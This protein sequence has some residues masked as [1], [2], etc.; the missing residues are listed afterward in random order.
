MPLD[1]PAGRSG[2]ASGPVEP[3][4]ERLLA[5]WDAFL[6]L[7][8]A[9]ARDPAALDR[10]SRLP[11][12]RAHD[13]LVHLGSWPDQQTLVGVLDS[14]RTGAD[15][16]SG[17]ADAHN[18]RVV[19]A[20]RAAPGPE[21]LAALVEARDTVE[22]FVTGPEA[23][24]LGR[25]L[26]ASAVGPMPVLA[27]AHAGAYELAVHAL[28]LAPAGAPAPAP[29]LLD[30][31]LGALI[32]VTGGLAARHGVE[33]DVAAQTPYGG[34]R[35]ASYADGGWDTSPVPA[36]PVQGTAVLGEAALLLDVSGGRVSVPPQLVSGRLRVQEMRSF[37]RL[38][39]LV[40]EVPGLPGGAAL[41]RAVTGV[42][43]LTAVTARLSRRP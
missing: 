42:R 4:A 24:T 6:D 15:S 16:D 38:A 12:W 29:E 32:D 43:T 17:S 11:G 20:H 27:L 34:W 35:F 3:L 21:V 13:V 40:D 14:A 23:A 30:A 26:A 28:D 9:V 1:A 36:G 8:E 10:P 31:G 37:L 2:L 25:T 19:A 5:A 39:P 18:A 22:A 7:A 41:R 33:I